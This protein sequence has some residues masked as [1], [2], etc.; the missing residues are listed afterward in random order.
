MPQSEQRC[1]KSEI[2]RCCPL[3]Q[4]YGKV[5]WHIGGDDPEYMGNEALCRREHSLTGGLWKT[6]HCPK[7]LLESESTK[8]VGI[9]LKTEESVNGSL[10]NTGKCQTYGWA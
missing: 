7:A 9:S 3:K 4:R 8:K 5:P 2:I 6:S 10:L 1:L